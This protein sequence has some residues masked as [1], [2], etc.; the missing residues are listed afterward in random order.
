MSSQIEK[1]P[2]NTVELLF[3]FFL[4]NKKILD[5]SSE[6]NEGRKDPFELLKIAA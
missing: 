5:L 4:W 2:S 1:V 6:L 3:I